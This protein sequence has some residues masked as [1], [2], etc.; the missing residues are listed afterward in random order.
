MKAKQIEK[1]AILTLLILFA[2][3]S[4]AVDG[5]IEINHTCA[6]NAGCF[7]GDNIGYPVSIDGVVGSSYKLTSDLIIPD[8]NTNGIEINVANIHL[9]LNG[10]S[11]IGVDCLVVSSISFHCRPPS[12][13]GIGVFVTTSFSY[14]V[15]IH[16]GS[17]IG[18]GNKG[19]FVPGRNSTIKNIH[20]RWNRLH[21]IEASNHS[22]L[23]SNTAYENGDFGIDCGA[24]CLIQG[25]VSNRNLGD[26]ISA[27]T[28]SII[29]NN[30]A[31]DNEGYGLNF[32]FASSGG[33]YREN[34]FRSNTTGTVNFGLNLGN[35]DCNASTVCP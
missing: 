23:L 19:L 8:A 16:N 5:V 6:V 29:I 13:S 28:G 21:G 27:S 3:Q 10:F 35:N 4:K 17:V 7:E 11:I 31:S 18:M 30:V 15:T 33:S 14:G 22:S 20:A 32:G 12:G 25:N 2:I 1:L 24:Y 26:G 34:A 9:D